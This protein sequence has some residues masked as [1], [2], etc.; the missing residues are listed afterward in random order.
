MTYFD[1]QSGKEAQK[2]DLNK[3][4]SS[5]HEKIV[6]FTNIDS[7]KRKECSNLKIQIQRLEKELSNSQNSN[8]R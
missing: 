7:M 2:S 4:M 6:T 1:L 3:K 8:D 5:I